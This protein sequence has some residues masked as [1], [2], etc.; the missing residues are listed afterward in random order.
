VNHAVANSSSVAFRWYEILDPSGTV[1]VNQQGTFAPDSTFRWMASAAMDKN[2]DIA[3]GFSASSSS[4]NPA[5]R[6]TGRVP[7][8][9]LGTLE[10]EN[11]ILEGTGSQITGLSRWGDYTALQVD[12]SDDC[13]FW[14]TN[15]Y[16]KTNGTFNW[17]THIGSFAFT[18]C[19]GGGGGPAVTLSLT[20]LKFGKIVVG[21]TSGAKTVTAT[22]AGTATLNITSIATSGD[23]MVK[24]T[25]CGSLLVAGANCAVKV[26][27][28]PTQTGTRT[29]ALTLTDNAPNSP[30]NVGLTGTGK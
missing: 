28:R 23:F 21:K 3:V 13:T 12:P 1:T 20:S 17:S 25:T 6:F 29:G 8:D 14:Y 2:N 30:Q 11:S 5:I 19:G 15:Q 10:T 24:S 9:A 16:Q 27:F 22:N 4:I 18:G 26:T 7:G